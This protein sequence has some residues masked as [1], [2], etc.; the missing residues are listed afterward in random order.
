MIVDIP[1]GIRCKN[2]V[3]VGKIAIKK[4]N[5]TAQNKRKQN[6]RHNGNSL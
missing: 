1:E 3:K 2:I 5:S 6:K 4:E